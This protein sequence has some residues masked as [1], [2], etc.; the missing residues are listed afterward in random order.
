MI[1]LIYYYF[2]LINYLIC[3]LI[4]AIDMRSYSVNQLSMTSKL[5][6]YRDGTISSIIDISAALC[7]HEDGMKSFPIA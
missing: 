6:I 3:R 4:F 7:P 5:R 2:N 1:N